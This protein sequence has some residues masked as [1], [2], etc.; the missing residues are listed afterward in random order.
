M[1]RLVAFTSIDAH[2]S[3]KKAALL[4]GIGT[5]NLYLV[6]TDKYGKMDIHHLRQQ[7]ERAYCENAK[8]FMVLATAGK[9]NKTAAKS[10]KITFR[11]II[12]N[13]LNN[14]KIYL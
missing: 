9:K 13:G 11:N 5:D 10:S 2:Y 8:P 12:M 4:L 6:D 7:I 1:P 3:G 14:L